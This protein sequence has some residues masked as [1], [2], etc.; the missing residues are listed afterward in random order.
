MT[1]RRGDVFRHEQAG[2]GG[3]GDP[4]A[5]DPQ[6]V[7][8][9]V[10]NELL[11]PA[12][13]AADYGVVVDTKRWVVDEA[14]TRRARAEIAERRGWHLIEDSCEAL[15]S[16]LGGRP[17]G[18]FGDASAFAFYPNKQITSGDGGVG[19]TDDAD[20]AAQFRSMRNQG[21]GE[22]GAWLEHVRLGYNY[23]MDELSAAVGVAQLER[24]EEL[25]AGRA[26]VAAAY[27]R[28]LG[29]VDWLRLPTEGAD[30]S[31]DWFVYVVRLDP[32]LDRDRLIV[33]L[34]ELGIQTRPYFSPIHTQPFIAKLLGSRPGD[35][36][37]TE[38][39]AASTIAIPWSPRMTD[40]DVAYVAGA[41]DEA[42]RRQGAV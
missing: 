11:S 20:L 13:A 6:A 42:G 19:V 32:G 31:V 15:G 24:F 30:E 21:R 8:R 16:S 25:R 37:V 26:R 40:D 33:D 29:G 34:D 28:E 27:Q 36:P 39:I 10:R 14:A 1:I 35:F 18:S 2:A 3:W 23:R 5:R 17:L 4:F 12:K 38:R 22:D 9:D 41:I 7:L